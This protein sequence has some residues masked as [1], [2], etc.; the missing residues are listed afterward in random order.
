M[1]KH[2]L[3]VAVTPQQAVRLLLDALR[4]SAWGEAAGVSRLAGPQTFAV[5]P[6]SVIAPLFQHTYALQNPVETRGDYAAQVVHVRARDGRVVS[7]RFELSRV[8]EPS[9]FWQTHTISLLDAQRTALAKAQACAR[10]FLN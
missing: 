1:Y 8:P 3:P 4:D 2:P 10:H 5:V 7:Y 9:G 6:N